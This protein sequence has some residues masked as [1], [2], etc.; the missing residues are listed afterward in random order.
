MGL[1]KLKFTP[2]S[3]QPLGRDSSHR[4]DRGT[5]ATELT[6]QGALEISGNFAPHSSL[7]EAQLVFALNLIADAHAHSAPYAEVHIESDKMGVVVHVEVSGL[8]RKRE[9]RYLELMD[10]VLEPAVAC[11]VATRT[12]ERMRPQEQLKLH[13]AAFDEPLGLGGH[14]HPVSGRI[15]TGRHGTRP[16]PCSDFYHAETACPVGNKT[17]VV[18]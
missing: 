11:C 9:L 14:F 4:T 8:S 13:A 17:F 10:E 3:Y 1:F 6:I 15:E 18:T 16:T 5:L 12:K 2:G 7:Y